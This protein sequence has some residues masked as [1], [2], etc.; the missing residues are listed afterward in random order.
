MPTTVEIKG[1]LEER[2]N[3]LVEAGLY[4]SRSEAIRDSI[5]HLLAQID[6]VEVAVRLYKEDKISL[7]K[8]AEIAGLSIPVFI[9]ECKN[10]GVNPK[11]GIENIKRYRPFILHFKGRRF[12]DPKLTKTVLE[13]S[14]IK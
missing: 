11:R 6:L 14:G 1:L 5:R 9:N 12:R 3:Q 10:R 13:N 8:G 2:L 7:G 4:A